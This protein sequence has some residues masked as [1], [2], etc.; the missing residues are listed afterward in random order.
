M[1]TNRRERV[2]DQAPAGLVNTH[3]E[4]GVGALDLGEGGVNVFGIGPE[5]I[6]EMAHHIA[7]NEGLDRAYVP[8]NEDD[9]TE[10]LRASL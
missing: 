6:P 5:R 8:L 10:I 1:Q 9:I 2:A 7:V 4:L 3:A